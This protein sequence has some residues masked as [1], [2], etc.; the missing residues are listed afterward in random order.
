MT[1]I[2]LYNRLVSIHPLMSI[3]SIVRV[4]HFYSFFSFKLKEFGFRLEIKANH[5]NSANTRS[6]RKPVCNKLPPAQKCRYL[7]N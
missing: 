6:I 5:G 3:I 2:K 1:S 7:I 4:T